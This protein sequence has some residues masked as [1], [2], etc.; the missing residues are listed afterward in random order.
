MKQYCFLK[1]IPV[2]KEPNDRSEMVSQMLIGES[3]ERLK[4]QGGWVQIR[5]DADG[6]EG[7]VDA[8]QVRRS[9]ITPI[10]YAL[11]LLGTPYLWGGRTEA[12]IDCSGLTQHCFGKCGVQLLRDASQQVTQGEVIKYLSKAKAN[13]LCFFVRHDSNGTTPTHVGIYM[14][15]GKI[16]HASG[17]VRIDTLTP[18]GIFAADL[19]GYSHRL[20]EIR[21]I[22]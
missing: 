6:Y 1:A 22:K 16:I 3:G 4:Q 7:W 20:I 8:K 15:G 19:G 17:R 18:E 9:A 2:R 21:R 10:D 5:L 12:G 11:I 13:D 14:G